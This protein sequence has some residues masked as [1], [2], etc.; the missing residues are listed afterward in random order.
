[1]TLP[2]L[3]SLPHAGL[4][5]PEDLATNCLL[6]P[7][8]IIADGD[9]FAAEIYGPL[10]GEVSRFVTTGIAR[11]VVDMNRDE[12][13]IRKDGVVKTHTCWDEPIWKRPLTEAQIESLLARYHRPY[14]QRLSDAGERR[15]LLGV[16]CHT[17]AAVGPPVGPDPGVERP[18]VCLGDAGGEACPASWVRVLQ[19][20][21]QSRFPGRVT[22]NEP[23]SG[24]YITR[25]HGRERPW[26]QIEISRGDFASPQQKATWV[27]EA[28]ADACNRIGAL[29]DY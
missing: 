19:E 2:L 3:V 5:V 28:L 8:Q 6:T 21:F 24:G 17:M 10:E 12:H 18:Q 7:Q 11:A 15:I 26:V 4:Q 9:E 1:M 14:H 13:D 20:C 29:M 25:H 27:R 23:F 16:D 22:R